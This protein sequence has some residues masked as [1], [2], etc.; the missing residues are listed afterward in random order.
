MGSKRLKVYRTQR[1]LSRKGLQHQNGGYFSAFCSKG[2]LPALFRRSPVQI[3]FFISNLYRPDGVRGI[4]AAPSEYKGQS[5]T[6]P[7]YHISFLTAVHRLISY[8]RLPDTPRRCAGRNRLPDTRRRQPHQ[9][10]PRIGDG[11]QN[12]NYMQLMPLCSHFNSIL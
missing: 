2:T 3:Q 7:P 5:L 1:V 6:G 11:A 4:V 12:I 9:W 10:R 8:L